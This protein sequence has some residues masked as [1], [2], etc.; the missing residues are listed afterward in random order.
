MFLYWERL[1][2]KWWTCPLKI[3]N[4]LG[5]RTSSGI[6]FVN[7]WKYST[8]LPSPSS[9]LLRGC[10][11]SES[12]NN[13][14]LRPNPIQLLLK[15]TKNSTS[16]F[17]QKLQQFVIFSPRV[18]SNIQCIALTDYDCNVLLWLKSVWYSINFV[19]FNHSSYSFDGPH[20][21][22]ETLGNRSKPT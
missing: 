15:A 8:R 2:W 9:H 7:N 10:V 21:S 5:Y 19:S 17:W 12:S 16:Q 22:H 20:T 18:H 4:G 6:Y 13:K 14:I 1:I 11:A 3:K